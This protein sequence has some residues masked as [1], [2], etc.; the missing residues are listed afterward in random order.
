MR[1]SRNS[2][3]VAEAAGDVPAG[4]GCVAPVQQKPGAAA[5]TWQGLGS[6]SLAPKH[7]E[8]GSLGGVGALGPGVT[9]EAPEQMVKLPF[10]RL[11]S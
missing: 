10:L 7:A 6:S 2:A 9:P 5:E 1:G 3:A 11:F 4:T 8:R